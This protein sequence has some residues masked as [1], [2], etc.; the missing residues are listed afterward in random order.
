MND[1]TRSV[2]AAAPIPPVPVP[3]Y[4]DVDEWTPHDTSTEPT[5]VPII[6]RP[7]GWT[8]FPQPFAES[9]GEL[10]L[11]P[12]LPPPQ[13][14]ADFSPAAA[15][16]PLPATAPFTPLPWSPPPPMPP[17]TSCFGSSTVPPQFPAIP[18][19]VDAPPPRHPTPPPPLAPVADL[20]VELWALI[21]DHFVL[22]RDASSVPDDNSL[23]DL[24]HVGKLCR[25]AYAATRP[26]LFT[27][28]VLCFRNG[29]RVFRSAN[30]SE[31]LAR[32]PF[33]NY[34]TPA[35]TNPHQLEVPSIFPLVVHDGNLYLSSPRRA[36]DSLETV[37]RGLASLWSFTFGD[38][39]FAAL[40]PCAFLANLVLVPYP[41]GL[42][43]SL[44]V[45]G[46]WDGPFDLVAAVSGRD[47]RNLPFLAQLKLDRVAV[48]DVPRSSLPAITA[49]ARILPT[50]SDF[51]LEID[52]IGHPKV[53]FPLGVRDLHYL[54]PKMDAHVNPAIDAL[55]LTEPQIRRMRETG[56]DAL[57]GDPIDAVAPE[58][59]EPDV[60]DMSLTFVIDIAEWEAQPGFDVTGN[61]DFDVETGHYRMYRPCIE[62]RQ[63]PGLP[64][65]RRLEIKRDIN[66]TG[67]W[68][69]I[70]AA[71]LL[72]LEEIAPGL[73]QLIAPL[74]CSE[75][76]PIAAGKLAFPKLQVMDVDASL[77]GVLAETALPALR[78]IKTYG[79]VERVPVDLWPSL[80]DVFVYAPGGTL[81]PEVADALA[82]VKKLTVRDL[83]V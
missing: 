41:L 83:G 8:P 45:L 56:L 57:I 43:R 34:R 12:M 82:S 81:K 42:V 36:D 80:E 59:E 22:G 60:V 50:V 25:A 78:Q 19:A 61:Y 72:D 44:V 63:W 6:T 76:A 20:P 16:N 4:D 75:S 47:W 17:P 29:Q 69:L 70:E 74:T 10:L 58:T 67:T 79:A 13:P 31:M 62:F 52:R 46:M 39:E 1:P 48:H 66:G 3:N 21:V 35:P 65:L 18:F 15:L 40:P 32:F 27:N 53:S 23:V 14:F 7:S 49:L 30:Q 26:R 2:Y 77:L 55:R 71:D 37:Q 24:H 38:T 11:T 64:N 68:S 54:T 9:F 51:H 28:L 33:P 73:E 5:R